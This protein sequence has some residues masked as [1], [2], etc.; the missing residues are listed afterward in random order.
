M[1]SLF[2]IIIELIIGLVI[3]VATLSK[4]YLG[5]A[6]I[7][8]SQPIAEILPRIPLIS[9]IVPI[10]G[11]FTIIGLV[12]HAKNE[13][14][15]FAFHFSSLHIISLLL[16]F[17]IFI[18]HP[19]AAWSASGRNWV[20][21]FLQLWFLLWLAGFLLNTPRKH[22]A[23]MWIF[24]LTALISA[25]YAITQGGSLSEINP[26]I[27]ASGLAQGANTATRYFVIA[28]VFFTHLNIVTKAKWP[29]FFLITGIVI[30]FLG[31]FYTASRTGILLLGVAFI[32]MLLLEYNFKNKVKIIVISSIALIF[33]LSFSDSILKLVQGIFP[34]I[35]QGT[36]TAGLRY[37]L[38]KA[39]L[40]MWKDHP[41]AGVGIGMFP[42][43]LHL[44]PNPQYVYYFTNGLVA[45]N[46]YV[47]MLAETGIIGVVLFLAMLLVALNNF[48]KAR[49]IQDNGF[50]G[51][52]KTWMIVFIVVLAGGITKTDQVDKVLWLCM[53]V[54]VFF[55]NY[56][57][58]LKNIARET[59]RKVAPQVDL[60]P[61]PSMNPQ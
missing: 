17:W 50:N 26:L 46:M 28:F 9:S 7:L 59:A 39:G 61:N 40:Q 6:F 5:L 43:Q 42:S 53:G 22:H 24:S 55:S 30:T 36:D 41:V 54:S 8:A 2:P 3:V 56:Q 1:N 38:W 35:S 60:K 16:I 51:I 37:A 19:S 49:K 48:I 34:S 20:F 12:I 18:S 27:R 58:Y 23:F 25:I 44:Y 47:S 15:R 33:L 52:S 57:H 13:H 11:A 4:P 32:L 29:R 31:V 21:T 10:I 45:H 14:I